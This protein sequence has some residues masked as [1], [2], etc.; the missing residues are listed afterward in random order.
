MRSKNPPFPGGTRHSCF[1]HRRRHR[2]KTAHFQREGRLPEAK[3][4]VI[5]YVFIC[6]FLTTYRVPD[7]HSERQIGTKPHPVWSSTGRQLR[8][9]TRRP[10]LDPAIRW[11]CT[12]SPRRCGSVTLRK[13]APF[14]R[15]LAGL[16]MRHGREA[17]PGRAPVRCAIC[18]DKPHPASQGG[19]PAA[20][21]S[22]PAP[23][24]ARRASGDAGRS[25]M[26]AGE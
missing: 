23:Q 6:P 26:A 13:R 2:A 16:G 22:R 8:R 14:T 19:R 17:A 18:H 5:P 24:A 7:G 10:G 4:R 12:A 1:F 25:Q 21:G 9:R 20:Q 3:S 15:D 11:R